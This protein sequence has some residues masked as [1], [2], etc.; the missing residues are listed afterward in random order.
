M[1]SGG[2]PVRVQA[3]SSRWLGTLP[4]VL[5]PAPRL[6]T[7]LAILAGWG[8]WP[9]VYT[10]GT[11]G[12]LCRLQMSICHSLWQEAEGTFG[13]RPTLLHP[14]PRAPLSVPMGVTQCPSHRIAS[15]PGTC[16][17]P[18]RAGTHHWIQR[19]ERGR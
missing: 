11:P 14:V 2:M 19:G 10:E 1:P 4:P 13:D 5:L 7:L 18:P 12:Q 6:L 8:D 9:C 16:A 17:H 15:A 3:A